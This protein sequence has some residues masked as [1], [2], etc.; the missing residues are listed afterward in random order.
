[1]IFGWG[2]GYFLW[3]APLVLQIVMILTIMF[4]LLRLANTGNN[5]LPN[6]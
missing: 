4:I 5:T 2:I 3:N 1:M 6:Q